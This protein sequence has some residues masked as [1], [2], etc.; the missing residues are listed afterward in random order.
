MSQPANPNNRA[1]ANTKMAVNGGALCLKR[2]MTPNT[3]IASASRKKIICT[4]RT[5]VADPA[6]EACIIQYNAATQPVQ[7]AEAGTGFTG[8]DDF[9]KINPL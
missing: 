1:S 7:L 6:E 8:W 2:V 9:G 4:R 3:A 5:D